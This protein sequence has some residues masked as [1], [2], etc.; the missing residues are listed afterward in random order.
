LIFTVAAK[1]CLS[2]RYHKSTIT[3]DN[4]SDYPETVIALCAKGFDTDVTGKNFSNV[5]GLDIFLH[6]RHQYKKLKTQKKQISRVLKR[7]K[8]VMLLYKTEAY[9]TKEFKGKRAEVPEAFLR[10]VKSHFCSKS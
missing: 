8:R 10:E 5:E 9:N 7:T 1:K 2:P 6:R 4:L 3:T